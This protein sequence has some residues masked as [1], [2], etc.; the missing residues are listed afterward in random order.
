MIKLL[1]IAALSNRQE[2]IPMNCA[3]RIVV[4][5]HSL[6][7]ND[8]GEGI[9]LLPELAIGK[10]IT[11]KEDSE[12][13]IRIEVWPGYAPINSD[14]QSGVGFTI[15]RNLLD[16]R[17]SF[18]NWRKFLVLL[19]AIRNVRQLLTNSRNSP[20]RSFRKD[21]QSLLTWCDQYLV[22]IRAL[23]GLKSHD[24]EEILCIYSFWLD[25]Y[26]GAAGKYFKG[27]RKRP[28]LI[29]RA[30]GGDLYELQNLQP[31]QIRTVSLLDAVYCASNGGIRALI[32]QGCD[33][34]K[35]SLARMSINDYV[36]QTRT[37]DI[38]P[39]ESKQ[40]QRINVIA[41]ASDHPV[42]QISN[43]IADLEYTSK[44]FMPI[45]LFLIGLPQEFERKYK[46]SSSDELIV[47]NMGFLKNE[48][49]RMFLL[50]QS[51]CAA[52]NYSI[53]EA[54]PVSLM[55]AI[56]AGIPVIGRDVGGV[57][58]IVVS[59][60]TGE[61]LKSDSTPGELCAA[62]EKIAFNQESLSLSARRFWLDNFD[63]KRTYTEFYQNLLHQISMNV[64][65]ASND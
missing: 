3:K 4:I 50:E 5:T 22:M 52:I 27:K 59:G 36:N 30:H 54:T 19:F 32:E 47:S 46:T 51:F 64:T 63:A 57:S 39:T 44:N 33:A 29:S 12:G 17:V 58:E 26:A 11:S 9:F 37:S 61:L 62:I 42:K 31:N 55:E 60:K 18:G 28:L 6:P 25:G 34:S 49:V 56:C 35:I 10:S 7:K 13:D 16:A 38:S 65:Q 40:L 1:A 8:F 53:S 41:I 14:L 43:L 45:H 21:V 15:E 2:D 23:R 48:Q 20:L 24:S